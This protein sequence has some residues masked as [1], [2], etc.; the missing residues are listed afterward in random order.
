MHALYMAIMRCCLYYF[1]MGLGLTNWIMYTSF[2][3]LLFN[4]SSLQLTDIPYSLSPNLCATCIV[5]IFCHMQSSTSFSTSFTYSYALRITRT[6]THAPNRYF[7]IASIYHFLKKIEWRV[8]VICSCTRRWTKSS[9][10][11]DC[12]RG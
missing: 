12:K 4:L 10:R 3:R 1:L 9:V 6:C 7:T 8:L 5:P 11:I 2:R